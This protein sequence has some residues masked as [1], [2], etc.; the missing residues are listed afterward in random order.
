MLARVE[1]LLP[2]VQITNTSDAV[3]GLFL[4][5]FTATNKL[6]ETRSNLYLRT[7]YWS[8]SISPNLPTCVIIREQGTD[9]LP[10]SNTNKEIYD[11]NT[12]VLVPQKGGNHSCL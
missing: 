5:I 9:I 3:L 10:H 8:Y 1:V 11:S 4:W 7:V 12:N 2:I 6:G